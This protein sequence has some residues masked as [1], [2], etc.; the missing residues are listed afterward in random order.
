M[1]VV[2]ISCVSKK[3]DGPLAASE[4]YDSTWFKYA[5]EYAQCTNPDKIFILSAKYGLLRPDQV[6]EPYNLTLNSMR[7]RQRCEWGQN[8]LKE[9]AKECELEHDLFYILA[10][11]NYR[12]FLI[13]SLKFYT[14]PMK[15][16]GIG[17]QISFL[18][19]SL[20][21]A[22]AICACEELHMLCKNARKYNYPFNASEIPRNGIYVMFEKGECGHEG[23][24]IVRIGTH[25]GDDQLRS[26]LKQHFEMENKD[27]SIFRKNLGRAML[28]SENN[29][30]L[31]I[32]NLDSTSK[33]ERDKFLNI[34]NKEFEKELEAKI[35]EYIQKNFTFAIILEEDKKKRLELESKLIST[36]SLCLKCKASNLWLGNKSPVEKIKNSGLWQVNELYKEP[37][38]SVDI[39]YIVKHLVV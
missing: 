9:L 24:R 17:Q 23:E 4:L 39:E 34:R 13:P 32:W 26:R 8:I 25:T 1:R 29:D 14:V 36:V 22:H 5:Y 2:L 35:S 31:E 27:R 33:K 11:K 12:E 37:L 10:G 3:K 28:N 16:M 38:S 7:K 18:K 15:H 20:S 30:Y 21:R 6:I 19:N